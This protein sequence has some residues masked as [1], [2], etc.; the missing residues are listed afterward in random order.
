V[1]VNHV[2][3]EDVAIFTDVLSRWAERVAKDPPARLR[4]EVFALTRSRRIPGLSLL[5]VG[6]VSS[7]EA[8]VRTI[9]LLGA[10]STSWTQRNGTLRPSKAGPSRASSP[11]SSRSSS[12]SDAS[13]GSGRSTSTRSSSPTTSA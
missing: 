7:V 1:D 8:Y 6:E 13:S 11:T 2:E 12:T 5:E 4:D 3:P 9:D 10:C